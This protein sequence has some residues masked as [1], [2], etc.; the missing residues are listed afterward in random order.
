MASLKMGWTGCNKLLKPAHVKLGTNWDDVV[1]GKCV[2]IDAS[3]IMHGFLQGVGRKKKGV[4]DE[5]MF[6]HIKDWHQILCLNGDSSALYLI[7]EQMHQWFLHRHLYMAKLVV[8][9]FDPKHVDSWHCK[10]CKQMYDEHIKVKYDQSQN[11][12]SK[13]KKQA[14]SWNALAE[15]VVDANQRMKAGQTISLTNLRQLCCEFMENTSI[16]GKSMVNSI[17]VWADECNVIR[18][19]ARALKDKTSKQKH[20]INKKTSYGKPSKQNRA[21]W[22]RI[23]CVSSA[24]EADDQIAQLV[25][26]GLI[27]LVFTT[28]TDLIAC[29]C[30][31]VANTCILGKV[32]SGQIFGYT[33]DSIMKWAISDEGVLDLSQRVNAS[34]ND[35]YDYLI[36]TFCLL[37]CLVGNDY[38]V[39]A[40]S[41]T[42]A[43]EVAKDQQKHGIYTYDVRSLAEVA[44][45]AW[46]KSRNETRRSKVFNTYKSMTSWRRG[47]I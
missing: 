5:R 10:K 18:K 15:G 11:R 38:A 19:D 24:I 42:H 22:P 30:F 36:A 46:K 45:K 26:S 3:V 17:V 4:D 32:P 34:N 23:L 33:T 28:D 44:A 25:R 41:M 2:A 20:R 40:L 37:S 13:A 43:R 31:N 21:S 35:N 6:D 7:A 39:G 12:Q 47:R 16:V 8:F 14:A 1:A 29:G 9:V 27:D